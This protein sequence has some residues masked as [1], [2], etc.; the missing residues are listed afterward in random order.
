MKQTCFS[1]K[2]ITSVLQQVGGG[3]TIALRTDP[4]ITAIELTQNLA[5]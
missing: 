2:P 3:I 1:V 5:S 4:W